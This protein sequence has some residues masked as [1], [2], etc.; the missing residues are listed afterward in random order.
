MSFGNIKIINGV[1]GALSLALMLVAM[2]A[3]VYL[4]DIDLT[5]RIGIAVF[6]FTVFML[7]NLASAMLKQ[8]KELR[9]RQMKQN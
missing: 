3:V 7:F 5:T 8:Q 4:P 1:E 2:F 9:E 6:A